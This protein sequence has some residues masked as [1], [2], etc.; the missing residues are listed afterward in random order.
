MASIAATAIKWA[1]GYW[2]RLTN[3]HQH[4]VIDAKWA[5]AG[6]RR[7][8]GAFVPSLQKTYHEV[9]G[10]TSPKTLFSKQVN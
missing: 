3:S 2:E 9:I 5:L 7:R 8:I 1:L 6:E 10:Q 4:L